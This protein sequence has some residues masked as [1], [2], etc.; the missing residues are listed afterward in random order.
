MGIDIPGTGPYREGSVTL[1]ARPAFPE[2]PVRPTSRKT[3][4]AASTW[5]S[6]IPRRRPSPSFSR[7]EHTARKRASVATLAFQRESV[8]GEDDNA[9]DLEDQPYGTCFR[10]PGREVRP[11]HRRGQRRLLQSSALSRDT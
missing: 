6:V 7:Y 1:P 4:M 5:P 10:V 2:P 9:E 3:R 11:S 8:P